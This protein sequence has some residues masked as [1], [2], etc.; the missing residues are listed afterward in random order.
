MGWNGFFY[1]VHAAWKVDEGMEGPSAFRTIQWR[2]AVE[3]AVGELCHAFLSDLA[4]L[5]WWSNSGEIGPD[6]PD[7]VLRE[8][9]YANVQAQIGPGR[10]PPHLCRLDLGQRPAPWKGDFSLNQLGYWPAYASHLELR[11]PY[12]GWGICP[13]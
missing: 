12:V 5:L 9:W 13:G 7:R 11:R 4:T 10:A 1:T 2:D 3:A 8:A 6:L